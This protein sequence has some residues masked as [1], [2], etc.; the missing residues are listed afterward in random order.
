MA[1]I[2][3][4]KAWPPHFGMV[5]DRLKRWEVRSND[6]DFKAGDWLRLCE[7]DPKERAYSGAQLVVEVDRVTEDVPEGLTEGF[8]IMDLGRVFKSE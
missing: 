4:L 7:Y 5:R 1:E 8:V 2:H 6:R 3:E